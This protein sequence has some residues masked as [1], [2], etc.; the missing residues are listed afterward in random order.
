[1]SS[2]VLFLHHA[3]RVVGVFG[4][5]LAPSSHLNLMSWGWATGDLTASCNFRCSKSSRRHSFELNA[6]IRSTPAFPLGNVT[7]PGDRHRRRYAPDRD[8]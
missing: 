5:S 7:R 6:P 4:S 2:K 8:A 3:W 1:M